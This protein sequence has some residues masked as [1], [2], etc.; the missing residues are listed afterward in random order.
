[1]KNAIATYTRLCEYHDSFNLW[2]TL[3]PSLTDAL[4]AL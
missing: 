1:M 4:T 2:E 3:C